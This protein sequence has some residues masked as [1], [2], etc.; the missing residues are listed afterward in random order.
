MV[1]VFVTEIS[2][3][4]PRTRA[5]S[6]ALMV[7]S[8]MVGHRYVAVEIHCRLDEIDEIV[9]SEWFQRDLLSRR[10]D[11]S[12]PMRVSFHTELG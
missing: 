8:S 12:A 1:G 10:H 7:G 5:T 3:R 11:D 4:R 2:A 6:N 9:Q